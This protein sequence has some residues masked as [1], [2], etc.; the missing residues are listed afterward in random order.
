MAAH[1]VGVYRDMYSQV[2]L[3]LNKGSCGKCE[4]SQ[5]S[6]GVLLHAPSV[7][8]ERRKTER[9]LLCEETW[10]IKRNDAERGWCRRGIEGAR[11]GGSHGERSCQSL[12]DF[13][14]SAAL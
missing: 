10:R 12:G 9:E 3:P 7:S 1:R 11:E 8:G 6:T 4:Q 2:C 14:R 5:E 13:K